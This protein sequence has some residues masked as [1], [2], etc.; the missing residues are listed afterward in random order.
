MEREGQGVW[1]S[2]RTS[3]SLSKGGKKKAGKPQE[4]PAYTGFAGL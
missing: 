3:G 4:T 1:N 2:R